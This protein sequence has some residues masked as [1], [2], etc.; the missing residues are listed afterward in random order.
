MVNL[1]QICDTLVGWLNGAAAPPTGWAEADWA[2]C[3]RACRI[4]GVGPLLHHR[5]GPAVWLPDSF[6]DWLAQE[7]SHNT[8]RVERMQAELADILALFA[9]H[10]LPVIPLKG[11]LMTAR[12]PH[13]GLR[14][15][16]DIDL[17]L[18]PAD[19]PRGV[20]LLGELG[21][22][23]TTTHW[24]HTELVKPDNR[25]VVSTEYEHPDNPRRVELHPYCRETFGGPTIN[26][27]RLMWPSGTPPPNQTG[28]A[29]TV[30]AL[31]LHLLAHATY[32]FWQ[33]RG[34]LI[35]LVD[36]THL[37]PLTGNNLW[38]KVDG[39][40]TY[41]ALAL[42]ARYFP[43]DV[44]PLLMAAQQERVS[45]RFRRWVNALNLVNGSHLNPAAPGL[46]VAKALRFSEGRP[47]EVAQALRFALLPGITELA[48]DHPRLAKS[49]W[50]WLAYFLLPLD[51]AR[52]LMRR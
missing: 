49:N 51:W 48:L 42:L 2:A 50:P 19:L 1:L 21:Y 11:A 25:R 6:A 37:P 23:P 8:R 47:A 7:H 17:L 32:H 3:R 24:K 38:E 22:A 28:C 20:Q 29:P 36:L 4:H 35:H 34:R 41:P 44:D 10:N 26:L 9:H 40:F 33:G 13:S 14:P 30:E 52:R 27:T 16:A 43:A 15:M 18:R 39:R 46:Y 5:L 12:Y 31:Q 45:P